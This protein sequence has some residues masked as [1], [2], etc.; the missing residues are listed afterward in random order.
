MIIEAG[1]DY[2]VVAGNFIGTDRTG[3][4]ALGNDRGVGIGA[5]AQFNVVGTDGDG[6]ADVAERNVISG[7][8]NFG[9]GI[10]DPGTDHNVVAGNYIG[11]DRTGMVALG[12][13]GEGVVVYGG[14]ASNRVGTNGN[15]MADE[16]ER[17][18]ISGNAACGVD[19]TGLGTDNNSVAGNFIG[20]DVTGMIAL[21]NSQHGVRIK[22]GAKSNIVGTDGNGQHDAAKRNVLSGNGWCGVA[23]WHA[24][25]EQNVVAG[26]FIGTNATGTTPIPNVYGIE[27]N[28]GAQSNRIGTNGD[29]VA[30]EAERNII[31]GNASHGVYVSGAGTDHNVVAGNFI[32]T[33]LSGT[34]AVPNQLSGVLIERGARG[35]RVGVDDDGLGVEEQRNVISGNKRE[36][37]VIRWA[38]TEQNLIA[39]NFIGTDRTGLLDLGNNLSGVLI[40]GGAQRN[41]IGTGGVA[42]ESGRNTISG[43]GGCGVQISD[44]G[45]DY[46]VVAGNFIGTDMDGSSALP[47][48]GPGVGI[49]WGAQ[50]NRI[51]TNGDGIADGAERNIISG[52]GSYGVFIGHTGTD[53]N[54]VA[55]NFI[56]TIVDGTAALG[57]GSIGLSIQQGAKSN[58]IGTN[59]DGLADESERNIISGHVSRGIEIRGAGTDGNVVAG[60][61]IGTRVNGSDALGNGK[62]GVSITNGAKTNRIG[63]NGDGIA[64]VAERNIISGNSGYGVF[65]GHTGTDNNVVAGNFIGTIVDGTAALGNGSVGV[66]I[67]QGA[68]SNRI[69]TNGDGLADESERNVIS[70]NGDKGIRIAG[71]GTDQNRVAGNF[72]GTDATGT[73]A[74]GNGTHGVSIQQGAKSNRI[75][76]DGDGVADAAERNIISANGNRGVV[77]SGAGTDHNVVAGNLIGT[78]ASGTAALGQSRG[79]DLLSGAQFNRVGTNGDSHFDEAERNV[80]SGNLAWGVYIFGLGT[81]H[82]VVA[83]NYIGTDITGTAALGN[84]FGADWD[85]GG[86]VIW[87]GAKF[88]VLGTDGDGIADEAERN[89][90]SGNFAPGVAIFHSDTEHNA[91][92]GN[93]IGTDVT[94]RIALANGTIG[95]VIADGAQSNE[96]G[97]TGG[98]ANTIAFNAEAGVA[99]TEN[100]IG[101]SIRGNSIHSNGGLGIDLGG[102]GITPNDPGDTD[103]GPNNLQNSPVIS[104]A[105]PGTTTQVAGDFNSTPNATF[106]LDFYA[107]SEADL[108]GYGEGQRWLDSA[109]VTTDAAGNVSFD[110]VLAA[111]TVSGEVITATATD[112]DGNTSEFSNA[113]VLAR[114]PV[115]IDVKP[116]SDSN[117]INLASQGVIAV[118][119]LTSEDFD[120]SFVDAGSVLFAGASAVHNA[121]ED[122]DGDG[123]LDLVLHFRTQDTLLQEMYAQLLADDLDE[124]GVLDSNR[125]QLAVSL[126]GKTTEDEF[127]EGFDELDL[128]LSGKNL[129]DLLKDL[130]ATG[131][132]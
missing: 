36:G 111:A 50:S 31:S 127:F 51:G 93:Y 82:N 52:N 87:H 22:Q 105:R 34:V 70:G 40:H 100:S 24:G 101:N 16:A 44:L 5:G 120:A 61:F 30:D 74:L 25:T 64:D 90:I 12:N 21:G 62:Y 132:I 98:I 19:I 33:D 63:T 112:P 84:G 13:A 110:V 102:D 106:T 10:G 129:R 131:Q 47:N 78:D 20:A 59:G 114:V 126:T 123:D 58:R 95:V 14:A 54:V 83:G 53:N 65:I 66:S 39:G 125:Q 67:Q 68:K 94:G 60:N 43:N 49:T 79:V 116:G 56:G 29:S 41:F 15:G 103:S 75:G 28:G 96:I 121:L 92:A 115:Q 99:V 26:N 57:N 91:I 76:T 3:I 113:N 130:A 55:G 46:N 37:V 124:D 17:N 23:L 108:S 18:V 80:I 73:K 89:V 35:N 97:W 118:A 72:I 8:R 117:P 104:Q 7:N 69:G 128:F 1:T 32:G 81:D 107:S 48:V 27:I 45:S 2:N 71:S 85:V 86:I 4:S 6:V 122:V 9:M 11:T 38:G 88:N 119:I 77:I 109:V 42:D